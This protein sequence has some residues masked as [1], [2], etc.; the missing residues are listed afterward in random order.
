MPLSEGIRLC[1]QRWLREPCAHGH[2]VLHCCFCRLKLEALGDKDPG[3]PELFC[4]DGDGADGDPEG[5]PL[6]S[7]QSSGSDLP[8]SQPQPIAAQAI[9]EE[10]ELKIEEYDSD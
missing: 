7:S 9:L 5:L 4:R 3:V 2:A 8:G 10:E 6:P 1:L